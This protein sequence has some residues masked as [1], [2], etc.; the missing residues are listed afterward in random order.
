LPAGPRRDT[1]PPVVTKRQLGLLLLAAGL[2]V[3]TLA[4]GIDFLRTGAW[5]APGPYQ[6]MGTLAGAALVFVGLTLIPLGN[7]PA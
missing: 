3:L 1:L 5:G 4:L 7:R 6:T 2:G